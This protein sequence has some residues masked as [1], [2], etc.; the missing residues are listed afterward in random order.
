MAK[1][2]LGQYEFAKDDFEIVIGNDPVHAGAIYG[3]GEAY[4]MLEQYNQAME[5]LEKACNMGIIEACNRVEEMLED[6]EEPGPYSP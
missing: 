1:L 4:Y 2:G 5:D 3:R 6:R